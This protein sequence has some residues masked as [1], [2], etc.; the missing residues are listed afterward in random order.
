MA[1]LG[2]K[3]MGKFLWEGKEKSLPCWLFSLAKLNYGCPNCCISYQH[4]VV[5]LVEPPR[6]QLMFSF[7]EKS[8]GIFAE[9]DIDRCCRQKKRHIG[10]D[11]VIFLLSR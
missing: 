3:E 1:T 11:C 5:L 6:M 10:I 9:C 4:I 8:V 2:L 7:G